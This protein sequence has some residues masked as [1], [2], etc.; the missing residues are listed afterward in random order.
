MV[1]PDTVT[2]IGIYAFYYA[3]GLTNIVFKGNAPLVE[4]S[5]FYGTASSCIVCVLPSSTGWNVDIPGTWNGLDIRY[6][7]MKPDTVVTLDGMSVSV[8]VTW[9]D[10]IS[11]RIAAADGDA[12]AAL[13]ATA[14]NGRLSVVECY[15][16]GLDPEN[17][18]NDF[19]I[20]SF[21]MKV[22]GTPDLA[23]IVFEPP[24]TQ[25]NV[26]ATYKVKGAATL[27]GP[28]GDVPAGGNSAYRF[29]KVEVVLP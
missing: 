25:W 26:P 15:V 16:L 11:E 10:T 5:T 4:P 18:T 7:E 29:F 22:D 3:S 19:K 1:I 8:P 17:P 2:S 14:A 20:V 12:V 21:P 28:W 24:Q 6:Q 27:A 23:G 9:L 13:Q